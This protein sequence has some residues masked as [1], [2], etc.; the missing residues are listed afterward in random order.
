MT[1]CKSETSTNG[2]V[3]IAVRLTACVRTKI[4]GVEPW[5]A[6]AVQVHV[7]AVSFDSEDEP[8]PLKIVT[9]LAAG[10]DSG[11]VIAP[12]IAGVGSGVA[13]QVSV[14]AVAPLAADV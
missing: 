10:D 1:K 13:I 2:S 5:R 6:A 12:L 8:I 14:F 9:D 3:E 11:L 4:Y 7:T